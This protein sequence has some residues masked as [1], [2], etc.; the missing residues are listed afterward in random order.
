MRISHSGRTAIQNSRNL[1]AALGQFTPFY[2]RHTEVTAFFNQI[3]EEL[4][5]TQV[6]VNNGMPPTIAQAGRAFTTP[7]KKVKLDGRRKTKNTYKCEICGS[8]EHT[9]TYH[10]K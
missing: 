4:Q 3:L 6:N 2:G 1:Y 9:A 8:T 5:A 7:S 10:N